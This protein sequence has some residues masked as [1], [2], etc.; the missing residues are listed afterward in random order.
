MTGPTL[1]PYQEEAR[2]FLHEKG[3]A[4]LLLDMGLGKTAICLSAM[5]PDHLPVLVT[6][7]PRPVESV[8][9]V[10][11]KKWRPD[12]TCRVAAGKTAEETLS[13]PTADIVAISREQLDK[14][15]EK[16]LRRFRTFIMDELS[17]FKNNRSKRFRN[18]RRITK[19]MPYTWGLTGTPAPNGL[20]DL[21]P[22]M[23]LIDRGE[24]LERTLGSYR[25]R[26]FTEGGRL[27]SGVV[28]SWN[29]RPGAEKR[30]HER[31]RPRA[32]SMGT[33]G[34]VALP[35]V[36]PNTIK[37]ELP[38]KARQVYKEL[39]DDLVTTALG[40]GTFT[41]GNAASLSQRLRQVASGF[42][43]PDADERPDD[44]LTY[45]TLHT[46]KLKVLQDIVE[47]AQGSPVMVGYAY[48]AEQDQ[49][50]NSFK[51]ARTLRTARD[52]EDWNAGRIPVL[53][54]HP[55]SIG[56]GLNLQDGGH[57][58]V[59]YG[60]TFSLEEYQQMNK[61]LARS[62][63][64]HPVVIHHIQT[65]NTVDTAVL[66]ALRNKDSVQMALLQHL[67]PEGIL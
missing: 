20:L 34:R 28:T 24:C 67:D 36:T 16:H 46:E 35:P 14:V 63:Q 43:Y 30:I 18:A 40:Q 11:T 42:L 41:A 62:G 27:P 38:A 23:F 9:P 3:N 10:E 22:Q 39:K 32:L 56:H 26:Y 2:R 7:P 53:V 49:I 21:W 59:W 48:R 60:L 37:V 66:S 51:G 55:A 33:E 1:R 65:A 25:S 58:L 8:W 17:G 15:K 5:T 4:A 50:L 12:L 52:V 31:I 61:R 13:D 19:E 47:E 6:A 64:K 57:T 29:L 45:T 54:G 44:D